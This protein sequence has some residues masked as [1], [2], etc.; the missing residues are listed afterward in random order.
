MN[1][2]RSKKH[3]QINKVNSIENYF[4]KGTDPIYSER[5]REE[6]E[7]HNIS[8]SFQ[9]EVGIGE[10]ANHSE[11]GNKTIG[12]QHNESVYDTLN[13]KIEILQKKCNELTTENSKLLKENGKLLKD[14]SALKKMLD[15]SKSGNLIKD[16]K[17]QKLKTVANA[18]SF[19]INNEDT[20]VVRMAFTE[21]EKYFSPTQIREL[22]SVGRGKNNDGHFIAKCLEFLYDECVDVIAGKCGGDRKMKGKTLIS[23]MKKSLMKNMLNERIASEG[24]DDM[25]LSERTKRLNRLLGDGI[26]TITKRTKQPSTRTTIP[27]QTFSAPIVA[28]VSQQETNF[29]VNYVTSYAIRVG[30]QS[31]RFATNPIQTSSAELIQLQ[32][33][34]NR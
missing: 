14:N 6:I 22:R 16:L 33:L 28:N 12:N 30:T 26:Y 27:A 5:L 18:N 21:Q 24:V 3:L 10:I 4:G 23:P 13:E 34:S 20:N 32:L 31:K 11:I 8:N 7:E 29:S 17:I 9:T 15:S 19:V 2:E 25:V 1:R